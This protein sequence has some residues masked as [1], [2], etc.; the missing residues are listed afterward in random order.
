M[1]PRRGV[2]LRSALSTVEI[3]TV[4]VAVHTWAGGALPAAGW[5]AGA[6]AL[7]FT[8]GLLVL[9]GKVP[10]RAAV[11]ALVLAQFLLHCWMVVL[12]PASAGHAHANHLHLTWQMALAHVA[13]GLVTALVWRLRKRAVEVVLSWSDLGLVPVPLLRRV[14]AR[15]A[16]VLPLRRPLVVVPLRGPPVGLAA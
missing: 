2:V 7:V 12:A 6:A 8:A 11:P 1:L 9:R 15:R 4:L 13:G 14:V 16:P 5:I 10:L 3:M